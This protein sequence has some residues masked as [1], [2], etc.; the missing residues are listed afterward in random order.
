MISIS[1]VTCASTCGF[2]L[3]LVA[4]LLVRVDVVVAV[5]ATQVLDAELSGLWQFVLATLLQLRHRL[6]EVDVNAAVVDEDVVH[7]EE[8]V[9]ALLRLLELDEGILQRLARLLVLDNLTADDRS[10]PREDDFQSL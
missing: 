10:E 9:L 5:L 7:L 3:A 2:L 6:T 1:L 8:G 4:I